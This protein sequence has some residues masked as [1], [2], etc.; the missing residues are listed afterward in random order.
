LCLSS[1]LDD[2]ILDLLVVDDDF[3][4]CPSHQ[5]QE[6]GNNNVDDAVFVQSSAKE[7]AVIIHSLSRSIVFLKNGHSNSIFLCFKVGW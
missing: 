2:D 1:K 7:E 5:F 4:G 3:K 6:V